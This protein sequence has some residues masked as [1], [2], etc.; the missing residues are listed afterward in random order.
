MPALVAA[1]K[2]RAS[3]EE[4][5]S[6]RR[7]AGERPAVEATCSADRGWA[8]DEHHTFRLSSARREEPLS[9]GGAQQRLVPS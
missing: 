1:P 8:D 9:V 2:T 4:E 6:L 7:A 3:I 5:E